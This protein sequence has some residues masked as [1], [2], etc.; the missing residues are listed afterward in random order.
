MI[1]MVGSITHA[2]DNRSAPN[3]FSSGSTISSSQMNENFNFLASEIREKDVNCNNGETITD[4]IN[5]GYNSLTIYGTCDGGIMVYMLDP[6]PFNISLSQMANKPITHLIIKGGD[7]NRSAT[8][9][10]TTGG[11]NSNVMTN[12]YL[13][14]YNLTFNDKLNVNDGSV[15]FMNEVNFE[16]LNLDN[17]D[18]SQINIYGTSNAIIRDS[19]ITGELRA[20]ENS[21]IEIKKSTLSPSSNSKYS[22]EA[23]KNS[24]IESEELTL[25][26]EI[27]VNRG[28]SWN[29][30]NSVINSDSIYI[31]QNGSFEISDSTIN[32]STSSNSCISLDRNSSGGIYNL[33][34]TGSSQ[35]ETIILSSSSSLNIQNLSLTGNVR[36]TGKSSLNAQ[37]FNV[38]CGSISQMGCMW[39]DYNSYISF[40][41]GSVSSTNSPLL[42]IQWNSMGYL[43]NANFT[44][45]DGNTPHVDLGGL[46]S[47]QIN[48]N[49]HSINVS[50]FDLS[51]AR[52]QSDSN[53]PIIDSSC[54]HNN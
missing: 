2:S 16:S 48:G 6:A 3:V 46:S 22:L 53:S 26:G 24:H 4:A 8:I 7:S 36:I 34:M 9:Q 29:D 49:A 54:Q 37:N 11:M 44:R 42:S 27:N 13:Q 28:S 1:L 40:T 5:E 41:D 47:V 30:D 19:N 17:D 43:H 38:D 25:S 12:G 20:S 32:C 35:Y 51:L 45:S 18:Y 31:S 52:D 10:N 23:K 21:N 14:L 33:S 15:L 39:V 50:C